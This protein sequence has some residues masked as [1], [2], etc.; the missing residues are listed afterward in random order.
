M[1]HSGNDFWMKVSSFCFKF[2]DMVPRKDKII[3]SSLFGAAKYIC[4]GA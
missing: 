4:F 2:D 1:L 3:S